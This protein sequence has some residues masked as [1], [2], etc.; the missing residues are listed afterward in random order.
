M[1]DIFQKIEQ[2]YPNE[3]NL[4]KKVK[5][6]LIQDKYICQFKLLPKGF[7]LKIIEDI[8]DEGHREKLKDLRTIYKNKIFPAEPLS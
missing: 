7:K 3:R 2:Q 4:D 1:D 8:D 5:E 6:Y